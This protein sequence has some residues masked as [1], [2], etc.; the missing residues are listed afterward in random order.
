MGA[1]IQRT[2]L[3]LL[4]CLLALTWGGAG[5]AHE[6]VKY[7]LP[8]L[9]KGNST[10]YAEAV[11][12]EALRR[13][14][15]DFGE[16][17]FIGTP[18]TFPRKR[19][20]A[21]MIQGE[22]VNLSV[23]ITQPEWEK[24]LLSVRI[25]LDMGLQGLRISLIRKDSQAQF[26]A[27]RS[28]ADL[29]KLTLGV[30]A[31]W[32]T[33]KVFA[34]TGFKLAT[35]DSFESL[36]RM[37]IGKRSDFYPRGLE[38]VFPEFDLHSATQPDLAIEQDL[39][40]ATPMPVYVFVSPRSPRLAERMKAGLESMVKDGSLRRMLMKH[41]APLLARANLCKR[42]VIHVANPL[43]DKQ[44]PLKRKNLWF[45]PFDPADGICQPAAT[46]HLKQKELS[47]TQ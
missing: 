34:A 35:G 42:R 6:V 4:L 46:G 30:G 24:E 21:E 29:Q 18:P 16:F 44:T 5:L 12:Q 47:S 8:D 31:G 14:Q 43:L 22:R 26:S 37:L 3:H 38:E 28:L 1:R 7:P 11:L 10:N 9:A 41:H 32:S 45:D 17:E 19:L 39:L 25:P 13:T 40:I 15:G 27:V 33:E 36:L 2:C 20:L 23:A